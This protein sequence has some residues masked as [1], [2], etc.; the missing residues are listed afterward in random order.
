MVRAQRCRSERTPV[1]VCLRGSPGEIEVPRTV[2]RV[3]EGASPPKS[4]R[5]TGAVGPASRDHDE[6]DRARA[7]GGVPRGGVGA[8]RDG[9]A[10][11]AGAGP[12]RV[13]TTGRG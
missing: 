13:A 2:H 6:G 11:T 12:A 5:T 4:T 10:G 1:K 9:R 8:G 7:R 3:C